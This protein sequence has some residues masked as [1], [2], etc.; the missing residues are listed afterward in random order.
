MFSGV[1]A[2][3]PV[4]Y[5]RDLAQ[6]KTFYGLFGYAEQRSGADD[7]GAQWSYQQSGDHTLLLAVVHPPL[8]P[9]ALPLL[10]YLYVDDLVAVQARFEAAGH[11]SDL[12]GYPDH[13]PGGEAR[14]H[15]PDGNVVLF[16]Q[17]V[18]VPGEARRRP[19][20]E[21]ARSS[22][23]QQAAEAVG[24]R[25]GAPAGCQV[26]APDGAAC[27]R[28]AEVKLADPWGETVWGCLT[29]ADEALINARSAFIATEDGH[30]LGPWLRQRRSARADQTT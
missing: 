23:I 19:T 12:V 14:T 30:G 10:I 6:A 2:A 1:S 16:G 28:P 8:I 24:R 17:R 11:P 27:P 29:H 26:G 21:A 5:V 3:V 20:D 13:A 18:A 25:G 22:L 9:A 7:A 15:D 4:L